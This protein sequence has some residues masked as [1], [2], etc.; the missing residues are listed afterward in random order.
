MVLIYVDDIIVT[1]NDSRKLQDFIARLNAMFSL[2]DLG[3][4]HYF[5]GIEVHRDETGL[6]LSQAKYIKELLT[7]TAMLHLKPCST[8]M[9]VGKALSKTDGEALK[10]PT[11]YR[12]I[13]GG[14]QYLT[15]TRPDLSFVVNK[16]SQ[17]LQAPTTVHWSAA[18][19][20]LRY[21]KGT[22][23]HGIHIKFSDQLSITGYSDA[24]WACCPDD[25]KSIA[26]YCVYLGDTLVS[27]SSKKQAVVSRSSTESEYRALAHVAAEISWIQALLNE[28]QFP[29][30]R[31]P[32]SWCDNMGA[33]ALA[34][35]PVY[36]ARTKHI[37]LDVHFVRDKVLKKQLEVRYV[38]SSDQ[39]ADCLTKSLTHH[40]FHF[41]TDKLGVV[42]TPL[43]L[44]GSVKK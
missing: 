32:I 37:E 28:F 8:P 13:I 27:W 30:Q 23:N 42:E 44:R 12:S 33:S 35:N 16:L 9:T 15:H 24:D 19:R 38:P 11:L 25:R 17:Y 36:H 10:Q 4:L 18:K 3:P 6:Y 41:L 39:I 20:V 2:K 5:L 29:L 40:R 43:R 1:G 31:T 26:G 21:L 22:I 34:A 14:L 7:R